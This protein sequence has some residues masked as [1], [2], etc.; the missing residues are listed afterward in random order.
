MSIQ[1]F[2]Q[3]S[4]KHYIP[5]LTNANFNS[6]FPEDQYIYLSTP[7]T[8]DI[9]YTITPIG[10]AS[11]ITGILSSTNP[12]IIPLGS[13]NGQLFMLSSQT[14]TVTNNKGYIIEATGSVYASIR[15]NAGA[16]AG[17]LVSKGLSALGTTFRI[18]SFT[19]E[20]PQDNFLSFVSVMATEN[21]TQIRFD[22]LPS[23]LIIENYSGP[24]PVITTLNEGESYTIAIS[25]D[26]TSI[27]RDG[28]IG[29]L[30]SSDKPIVVN[31][32]S[33][34]G[35]FHNGNGRD[36]GIDQ[37]VDVTKVGTEYIFVKG[38]GSNNWENI[39][40][41][42]HTNNT[43]IS[44]NGNASIAT[45]NAG[46]YYVIEGGQYSTSG[47]M[48]VQTSQPVFA[49]QGIGAD[50]NS[51]ANQGMFFVP[52]L[53]CEARGDLDNIANIN[54]IG[55][56]N[57]TGGITLITKIGAT[58]TVTSSTSGNVAIGSPSAVTGKSD[59]ITY[60]VTGLSGNISV[61]STDE[62]YC[63]YY[64]QNDTATSGSFYSGFPSAPEI[65]F[66]LTFTP[67]G[68]CIPNAT[69]EISNMSN[70]SSIEWYHDDGTGFVGT[71]NNTSQFV[72]SVS[73]TYKAIGILICSGDPLESLEVPV[74]ICPDDVDVDGIIDNIDIDNDNDGILNCV[75]S[76]GDYDINLSNTASGSISIGGGYTYNGTTT[77]IGN[78]AAT[79]FIGD[80]DGTFLSNTP[81]K[82]GTVETSVTYDLNF[83]TP[84]N[85]MVE[86][87]TASSLGTSLLTN[88]QE[89]IIKVPNTRTI[90]L[91]DPNDQLLVDTNFDGIY[92]TGVTQFSAFE[93][94]FKL[95][96]FSLAIGSG[97]FSFLANSVDNFTYVHKNNSDTN[98]N[99][100]SFKIS[101][102]CI[103]KDTDFDGIEDALDLDSDND[104]LP[105]FVENDGF[106]IPL[107]GIDVDLNGLDDVYDINATL[108]DSDN[109]AV[110]DFYDL[111]SDNDGIYDL[112][113]SGQFGTLS[114][115]NL[116]GIE[117]GPNYGVNGWADAA[118]T[119]PDSNI[120]GYAPNDLDNDSIFSYIDLDSDG[121]TCSD[122]IEAGFSDAD[123]NAILGD[124]AITTNATGLVT[125]AND[126]YTLPDSNYLNF[127]P[128]I[129]T[130]Q[131]QD[132]AVCHFS[133]TTL[134]IITSTIG[135]IQWEVST[136]GINWNAITNNTIYS[137]S[138]TVNLN[139][140][141][142]PLSYDSNQYRAFLN[143]AGNSCGLYSD[144]IELTVN[145]LPN[146]NSPVTLVQ[147][148]DE[149]PTTLGYSPFNLKE[150]ENEISANAANETFTYFLTQIA[151]IFGD[152]TST[153]YIN[154]PTTFVNR[155]SGSDIVWARIES[156]FGCIQISEIQ[157]N[158]S[159][160]VIPTSFLRTFNQ[161]DDFLDRDGFD[162]ANNDNRDGIASFDFSSVSNEIKT[163]VT[164]GDPH[165]YRNETDAL[166][167]I[168]E[169]TD[170]SNYRNIGYP[171]SQF[172]YVRVDSDITNDCLALGA[173]VFLNVEALPIANPVTPFITC[174]NDT[175][176]SNGFSFNTSNLETDLLN[177]QSLADVSV[178]YFDALGTQLT[179]FDG[180][181]IS[182]PFPNTFLSSSQTITA[183]V[184][185]NNTAAPDG[186]CDDETTIEFR[187][188]VQPI[189]N[190]I[191]TQTVCDGDSGDLD[192]DGYFP[193]DTSTFTNTILGSQL[194]TMDIYYDYIDEDGIP[195]IDATS[196]PNPL[197]SRNQSIIVEVIN[198]KNIS[199]TATTN[200]ELIVNP[201]PEFTV[202][203]PRIVC[204]SD[205]S[206]NITLSPKEASIT[207]T[208][209]YTWYWDSL[210]GSITN[211][212]ISNDRDI[213][214]SNPGTYHITLTKTDGTNCPRTRDIFVDASEQA[215][216]TLDDID[217]SAPSYNHTVSIKDPS[218]LGF[219][220]YDYALQEEDSPFIVFQDEPVFNNLTP[221]FYTLHIRDVVCATTM[222][223]IPVIGHTQFFT[224][225][226]DTINDYWNIKGIS[227]T[228]QSGSVVL[229]FD[230]Y[231]RLLK[232][233]NPLGPG[234]DGTLNGTLLPT[235]DYWFRVY[236]EDGR[237]FSGHFTLKR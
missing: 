160:T 126:G 30:V 219:G 209:T 204:T 20:N 23:G 141:G 177:G 52:P 111:D 72:P 34:N 87:A 36:Y 45:I 222:L 203:T 69:L 143:V 183:R 79:P 100:A 234:W 137:G 105:D 85:L 144:E 43:T 233:I 192:N 154:N 194:G 231:G 56:T 11:S 211:Q 162:N 178:S 14:S 214:V 107:S 235:D 163:I 225:N 65:N 51:E 181:L 216:I 179:D 223:N 228:N 135:T 92:E 117:D 60:K 32:G 125:N 232:Q 198:P 24:T 122:V 54:N 41:V 25:S 189:A 132:T 121:D 78:V 91:L 89:F 103:G 37:I 197:I 153:D 196:L 116:D 76:Y 124:N 169:I 73:G 6:A 15:V 17:A 44:I 67:L 93:I 215:T 71:G 142:T 98:S 101:A 159:T 112:I 9:A 224:P 130:T 57:Y 10:Q 217:I 22:D 42:A 147:C 208:F 138:Q 40:I 31:C 161:C 84:L 49:Y 199:C 202:E 150:V 66:D 16:Q 212:F 13:G 35:S 75:E 62:L 74:S 108:L 115:T 104:G 2:S 95:N 230:R 186:P 227:A 210:D 77:P 3:L 55:S 172:I 174:D 114:D 187:V 133:S 205:P 165:F 109:D 195:V 146:V 176:S 4:N 18:G 140:T 5:P 1:G 149:D 173:H 90:T 123:N 175:D 190:Q 80:S 129:I 226:G 113:E 151:A 134:S 166:A 237:E 64:N 145:P 38:D 200:I 99:Q 168:N 82:N 191:S 152:L 182:S 221:G 47:N 83:N 61:Q 88:D 58:V 27:N 201:L 7:S 26:A 86:Y 120:I 53:S 128:I 106:L 184:T 185:N 171:G 96:T 213:I 50:P 12:A 155:T 28:L 119:T 207:E 48:Y 206:F 102:T 229:I 218:L 39:L 94:R 139:I 63:A 68:I 97:T 170:I 193:F 110:F 188:D 21:N 136:D 131:P 180:N 157:L 158:V 8:S 167:E 33:A 59:Y 118:E 127:A 70:F 220:E 236:L 164:T 156:P 148:D 29:C 81:N 19:N 46:D